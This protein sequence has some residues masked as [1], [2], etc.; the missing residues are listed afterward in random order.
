ML[1]YGWNTDFGGFFSSYTRFQVE[2]VYHKTTNTPGII[3]KQD[4]GVNASVWLCK[5]R[6][7]RSQTHSLDMP[8]AIV[9][10]HPRKST[11]FKVCFVFFTCTQL[12][13]IAKL[14]WQNPA[15]SVKLWALSH[16]VLFYIQSIDTILIAA[17]HSLNSAILNW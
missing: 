9:T 1:K 8:F 16:L 12:I 6:V 17:I 15:M 14:S 5:T 4:K 11:A 10:N 7:H 13:S 2:L 3:Q